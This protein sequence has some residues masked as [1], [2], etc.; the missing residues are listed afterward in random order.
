MQ[1]KNILVYLDDG[2]SNTERMKTSLAIA[3]AHDARITGVA[4]NAAPSLQAMLRA[5][6]GG[7]NELIEKGNEQAQNIVKEFTALADAEGIS[8]DTRVIECKEGRAPQKLAHL[9]RNF[10]V[11]VLRQA[12]P[13]R[14]NAELVMDVAEEVL[15]SSGRPVFF[16]PYIGTHAIP[17]QR[18]VIA[19]DGSA[20]ST[21]AVHDALPLM[22]HMKEVVVLVV[23][24]DRQERT[25][26]EKPGDDIS[27]HLN[28]HGINNRIERRLSD[29]VPTSTI[30]LNVLSDTGAD[31]LIMGGYGTSKL[32]EVV[33]GGVT[34]T[35]FNSMTV[36][37]FMSH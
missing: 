9:A 3:Q 2:A 26:G 4:L 18:A 33:L 24:A 14:P 15:F 35:L 10:D 1:Y 28:A 7:A 13:D 11:S 27:N 6:I 16:I 29:G 30:I 31:I 37:V 34:R 19:W 21:R 36:P 8:H 5:G 32:R 20:A 17:C 25:N 23:D 12:N 22:E